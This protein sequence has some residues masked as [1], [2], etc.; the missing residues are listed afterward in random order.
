MLR[1]DAYLT[2][3]L[4]SHILLESAQNIA[5]S[6]GDVDAD[7]TDEDSF[8]DLRRF[9]IAFGFFWRLCL[10]WDIDCCQLSPIFALVCLTTSND[11]S[12]LLSDDLLRVVTPDLFEQLTSNAPRRDP[13][14]GLWDIRPGGEG[15]ALLNSVWPEA[16][17][18]VHLYQCRNYA[19]H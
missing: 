3:H 16:Q 6:S 13:E 4:P 2:P 7:H 10:I 8:L 15:F 14:N 5:G 1:E 18:R 19:W 17:V 9:F 11:R 12:F